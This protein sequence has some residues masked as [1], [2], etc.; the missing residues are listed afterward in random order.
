MAAFCFGARGE[1]LDATELQTFSELPDDGFF[2]DLLAG[3]CG[4]ALVRPTDGNRRY[5]IH[6]LLYEFTCSGPLAD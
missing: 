5:S 6:S 3:A 1:T 2:A 4:L